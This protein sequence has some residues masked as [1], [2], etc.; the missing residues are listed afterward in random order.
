MGVRAAFTWDMVR[1]TARVL[2]QGMILQ[3]AAGLRRSATVLFMGLSTVS[4][5]D[6]I[7]QGTEH[8]MCYYCGHYYGHGQ[9]DM[10]S[11]SLTMPCTGVLSTSSRVA[12][13]RAIGDC[14]PSLRPLSLA[15]SRCVSSLR[16]AGLFVQPHESTSSRCSTLDCWG[17]GSAQTGNRIL[18]LIH[19]TSA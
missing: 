2:G 6:T 3:L 10:V 14:S 5:T 8:P 15:F 17:T 16:Y 19:C 9:R 12:L 13:S 11:V 1:P 4:I 7:N 18:G